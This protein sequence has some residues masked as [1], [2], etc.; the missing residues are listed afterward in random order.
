MFILSGWR[1]LSLP[2]VILFISLSCGLTSPV[3]PPTSDL[4]EE[5]IEAL[6]ATET[7]PPIPTDLPAVDPAVQEPSAEPVVEEPQVPEPVSV[8]SIPDAN[9][10]AWNFVAGDY[11][12]PVDV[13]HAGDNTGRIFIV[14]QIG[15]ISILQFGEKLG[16]PFLDIQGRVNDGEFEQGLLS[17]AFHPDYSNNGYFFVNYTDGSGGHHHCPFHRF[18]QQCQPG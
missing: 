3:S 7:T 13:Q 15:R 4:F 14:E 8:S 5:V 17:L 16:A 6:P 11:S 10:Y 18:T 12:K 1:R 9:G 2:L